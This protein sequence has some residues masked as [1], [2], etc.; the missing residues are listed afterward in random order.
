MYILVSQYIS[1]DVALSFKTKK[2]ALDWMEEKGIPINQCSLLP[3][4]EA[5]EVSWM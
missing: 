4:M 5:T 1:T 2:E 3:V